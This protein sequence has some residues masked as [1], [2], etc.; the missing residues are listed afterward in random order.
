MTKWQFGDKLSI[1]HHWKTAISL[2]VAWTPAYVQQ[3][4]SKLVKPLT[5]EKEE[6]YSTG[7]NIFL[8]KVL[9]KIFTCDVFSLLQYPGSILAEQSW[10]SPTSELELCSSHTRISNYTGSPQEFLPRGY[11]FST[12]S[13][14]LNFF[15]YEEKNISVIGWPFSR[16]VDIW[17]MSVHCENLE[18]GMTPKAPHIFRVTMPVTLTHWNESAWLEKSST[19]LK[20]SPWFKHKFISCTSYLVASLHKSKRQEVLLLWPSCI[21]ATHMKKNNGNVAE[22][23]KA[24]NCCGFLSGCGEKHTYYKNLITPHPSIASEWP[25]WFPT[26]TPAAFLPSL[27]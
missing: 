13:R 18:A 8:L 16:Y 24:S 14:D 26:Y 25:H 27:C 7:N 15:L 2:Q 21:L 17:R 10:F 4:L 6:I 11:S 23:E 22:C 3:T 20:I 5:T 19:Y 12:S 1:M 9:I